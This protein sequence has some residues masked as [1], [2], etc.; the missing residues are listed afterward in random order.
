MRLPVLRM[1]EPRPL[2][3]GRGRIEALARLSGPVATASASTGFDSESCQ[4]SNRGSV[5]AGRRADVDGR[6]NICSMT[7]A[8]H[9]PAQLNRAIALGNLLAARALARE[10]PRRLNLDEALGVVLQSDR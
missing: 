9:L 3:G 8:G 6:A 2:K 4:E 1:A 7:S 5:V 10:L